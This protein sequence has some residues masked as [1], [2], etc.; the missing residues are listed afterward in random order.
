MALLDTSLIAFETKAQFQGASGLGNASNEI[1]DPGT[2][3]IRNIPFTSIVFILD[4]KEIWTHG[5][6]FSSPVSDFEFNPIGVNLS[7][8][9]WTELNSLSNWSN[10]TS[11]SYVIQIIYEGTIYSG[12]MSYN[13]ESQTGD[14]EIILHQAGQPSSLG[15]QQRGRLFA[16]LKN[17]KL[18]LS[19]SVSENNVQNL[20]IKLK[21]LL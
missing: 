8:S 21:K 1:S 2:G 3:Y 9:N 10:L 16:K 4:S 5:K 13:K 7:S 18:C 11:G 20:T 14:D 15:G 6:Y 12:C 19:S 17:G